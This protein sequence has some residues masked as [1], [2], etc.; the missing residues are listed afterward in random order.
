MVWAL[1]RLVWCCPELY[2]VVAIWLMDLTAH[3]LSQPHIV[4]ST[5]SN[6][7]RDIRPAEVFRTTHYDAYLGTLVNRLES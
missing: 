1:V 5:C 3:L 7:R 2:F 4:I 6:I